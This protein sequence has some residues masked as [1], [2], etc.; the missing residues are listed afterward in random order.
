[1]DRNN[2]LKIL[3]KKIAPIKRV[4]G[5][6]RW[7]PP[8]LFQH[9]DLIHALESA[10]PVDQE[11]LINTLNH[12]HFMDRYI[13]IHLNHPKY[14]ESVLVQA[15]PDPCH[16]SKLTCRLL[17]ENLLSL[18][19]KN[20]QFLHLVI[21]D[22]RSMILVPAVLQEISGNCLTI[23]LPDA[24]YAVG[25]RQVR[26]YACH[27][28]VVEL[29]QSGFLARGE[30]LDF[31]PIG[32]RVRVKPESSSSFH[33]LNPEASVVIHL[34]DDK[35]ILFSG[36]CRCIRQQGGL[37]D[38]EI[39]LIPTDEKIKRFKK[40]QTRNPRQHLVP[41][42]TII[43]NHPFLKKS[44]QLG[45][46][47]I[48]TSG[49]SVYEKVDEGIL[50]LGMI[51]P[52]L[53]IDFAGTLRIKCAAQVIYRSEEKE[54][55]IRCGL[56][57]L[58]MDINTYGRLTHILTNAL[59]PYAYISSEIDMDALWE[60]F[61]EAGFIYPKKYRLIQSYRKD[62]KETYRRL[63]QEN[64]EIACHFTYQKNG[65]IY[66]HISMV[67]AYER[68]WMI[69]HH[70]AIALKDKR[71][72]LMV[73]KQIMY[74]LND[75][76][77]L[78]S[79]KTEYMVS[80]FRPENKFP[81][82]IF[83]GF[84]RDL[85]NPRGCSMDLFY[86]LP[87]TSLSLSTK[88]PDKWSLQESSARDLWELNRFYNH[89]SGGLLL[90]ALDLEKKEPVKEPLEE[91]YKRLGFLRKWRAYSLNYNGEL[92]AV[93]VVNQSDL[94]FN[95][96]ELLN[97]IKILVTN[98]EDLPWNILSIA[99][100]Q[101]TGIYHMDR[102]PVLFYPAEYVQNKKVPY[103]KQYQAWVLDVRYGNEYMEYMQKRFRITYKDT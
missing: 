92:N 103:E 13:L 55:G 43:F 24:S 31:S 93:L 89:Y 75:M 80:Y 57:I 40:R 61:F 73:L 86:Y 14:E 39:V 41:S 8:W 34:R 35:Q 102:V 71:P 96:S 76:H 67:K 47:D 66:G 5:E 28:V 77:R 88:L 62:F 10:N 79:A 9:Q 72:G 82:R 64:P 21:D 60:F 12:I 101:L 16:G 74:Y 97:G 3:P 38:K 36:L 32:F 45:V 22:G 70:A 48:S 52:E 68:A 23:Q 29:I 15:Y 44:V 95:L 18:E 69:H 33:W 59:D 27:D 49:F 90:D 87:Y 46:S 98:P 51:I 53:I 63:Y 11:D 100:A 94:G 4:P 1:M 84:A 83:G 50:M 7:L 54:K 65:R 85:K 25:Q 42:P 99:I 30:L 81:D 17:D 58:E 20:Y 78:P 19:L 2:S 26:R 6:E 91:I 56:A 37:Q